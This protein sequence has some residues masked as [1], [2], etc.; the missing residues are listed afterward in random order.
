MPGPVNSLVQRYAARLRY[1]RLLLLMLTLFGVDLVL[2]DAIPLVDELLLGI[3]TVL[4]G[5]LR[6]RR[7]EKLPPSEPGD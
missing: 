5:S 2:P 1:P 3:G 4:L 6:K 7:G